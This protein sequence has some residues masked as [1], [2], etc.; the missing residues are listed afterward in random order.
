MK[1]NLIVLP[2][3]FAICRLDPIV[4]IPEWAQGEFVTTP[5]SS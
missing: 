1:L 2:D 3:T 5:D 4:S